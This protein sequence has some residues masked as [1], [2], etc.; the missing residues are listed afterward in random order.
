MSSS[1]SDIGSQS[2]PTTAGTDDSQSV[3]SS[4]FAASSPGKRKFE[5]DAITGRP[6]TR[7]ATAS[8]SE[9]EVKSNDDAGFD[10]E[11]TIMGGMP[12]SAAGDDTEPLIGVNPSEFDLSN[13]NGAAYQG[14]GGVRAG[15]MEMQERNNVP[16]FRP[17]VS[18]NVATIA[19]S[20]AMSMG[21]GGGGE[22][23]LETIDGMDM[24]L[25]QVVQ[26]DENVREESA[27]SKAVRRV[28][29]RD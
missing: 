22:G 8:I 14:N 5:D 6:V 13:E 15:G 23:V 11:G 7:R 1:L 18:G 20:K 21:L 25:D 26:R 16:M 10:S 28:G 12:G 29:F 19:A 2:P 17:L 27:A 24:D 4:P 9:R 3:P